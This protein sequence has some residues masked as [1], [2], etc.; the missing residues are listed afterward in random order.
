[1][2][3]AISGWRRVPGQMREKA[4][5]YWIETG[6][7]TV[8]QKRLTE[9]GILNSNDKPYAVSQVATQAYVYLLENFYDK[10]LMD[11]VNKDRARVGAGPLSQEEF[12]EFLVLKAISLWGR[13]N[14]VTRFWDWIE[15]HD[16]EKYS[17]LWSDRNIKP[18]PSLGPKRPVAS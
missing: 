11:D 8:A 15:R 5:R 7:L 4:Y 17:Y 6:S 2:S 16:F 13:K 3:L 14:H 10:N 1:M 12:E 9:E 18:R